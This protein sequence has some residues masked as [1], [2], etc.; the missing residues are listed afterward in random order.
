MLKIKTVH[1]GVLPEQFSEVIARASIFEGGLKKHLCRQLKTDCNICEDRQSCSFTALCGRQLSTDPELVRLH[2]KPGVPFIFSPP[3][4][5]THHDTCFGLLLLG[6]AINHADDLI[7]FFHKLAGGNQKLDVYAENYQ[8]ELMQLKN[9]TQADDY[10][11]PVLSART[12]LDLW[13]PVFI[14]CYRIKVTFKSPLRLLHKGCELKHFIPQLFI[15]SA[16]RRVT[17]LAAYYGEP[18]QMQQVQSFLQAAANIKLVSSQADQTSQRGV[19][20]QF[21]ME[22]QFAELGPLLKLTGMLQ[23][24]KGASYGMGSFEVE[25]AA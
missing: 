11:F 23:L 2:Q 8:Q 5:D 14:C 9:N 17:A 22:G 15:K 10:D 13:A 18:M 25:V 7:T 21:I 12:M 6:Q 20:G 19:S 16:L 3:V 1:A 24:G 4:S